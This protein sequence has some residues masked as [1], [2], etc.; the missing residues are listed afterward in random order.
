MSQGP[1]NCPLCGRADSCQRISAIVGNGTRTSVTQQSFF[2]AWANNR[3]NHGFVVPQKYTTN[4]TSGVSMRLRAPGRPWP[5]L[6]RNFWYSVAISAG[7]GFVINIFNGAVGGAIAGG[8]LGGI[9]S[10][11]LTCVQNWKSITEAW[12]IHE[13]RLGQYYGSYY[14]KRD[15]VCFMPGIYAAQPEQYK[16]WLFQYN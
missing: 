3:N 1:L 7:I 12:R 9:G 8:I 4:S 5:R 6:T 16:A 13:G 10:Y 15:D 2:S 14:C 11:I